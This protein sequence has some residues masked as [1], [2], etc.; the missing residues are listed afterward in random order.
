MGQRLAQIERKERAGF[1]EDL[2]KTGL[3]VKTLSRPNPTLSAT[4]FAL[5][6]RQHPLHRESLPHPLA[7]FSRFLASVAGSSA[8]RDRLHQSRSRRRYR[9]QGM[10]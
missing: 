2:R 4:S 7:R 6:S 3:F 1:S 5:L 9:S 10:R 8:R